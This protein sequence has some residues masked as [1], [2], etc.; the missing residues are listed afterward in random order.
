MLDDLFGQLGPLLPPDG[1]TDPAPD[2]SIPGPPGDELLQ[3][4]LDRLLDELLTPP[5]EGSTDP[6]VPPDDQPTDPF[7]GLFDFDPFGLF[8]PSQDQGVQPTLLDLA[9]ARLAQSAMSWAGSSWARA[10]HRPV[11]VSVLADGHVL[12]RRA[13]SWQDVA[14]STS[15]ASSAATSRIQFTPDLIPSDIVGTRSTD[16]RRVFDVEP[17]SPPTSCWSTRSTGRLRGRRPPS[18]RRCRSGR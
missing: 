18:S 8:G 16:R 3:E 14:V 17:G 11:A 1:S 13:G 2:G 9:A 5:D 6:G 4:L 15:P 12:S 10:G 7:G